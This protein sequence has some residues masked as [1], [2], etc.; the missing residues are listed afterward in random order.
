VD[1]RRAVLEAS[2]AIAEAL[3]DDARRTY[4]ERGLAGRKR[5]RLAD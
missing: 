4:F 2:A 3:P 1:A 5:D